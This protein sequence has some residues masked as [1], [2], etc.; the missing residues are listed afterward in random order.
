[1][2][3]GMRIGLIAAFGATL[4]SLALGAPAASAQQAVQE[5]EFTASDGVSLHATV[6][7]TAPLQPRPLV[8]EYSP[9][10]LGAGGPP[11]GPRFNYVQ[12]H[13]RGTGRSGGAWDIM[14]PREQL[15]IAESLRWLCD[16]PWSSGEIGLYGFSASAIAA[17]HAMRRTEL[18]CVRAAALLAGTS[19][20]Y[21]DLVFIGG[22]PNLVPATVVTTAI[23]GGYLANLPGRLGDEPQSVLEAS[24]GV[25]TAVN[26]FAAHPT[27]DAFWRARSFPGPSGPPEI[28]I[29]AATGFYDVE[30]RGPF[31]TFRAAR[32]SG[33][34]LL[35]I[36]AHDGAAGGSGG[37]FPAFGRW[38]EHHLLGEDNGIDAEPRV[39]LYV[40]HGGHA[41]L[42]DGAWTKVEAS[43]WPVPG[44][45]WQALHLDRRRSG[46]AL[47]LN[48]GSLALEPA[49]AATTQSAPSLP[50]NPLAT[51]P[52]T[53]A[54]V[55]EPVDTNLTEATSLTYTTPALRQP[56]MSVGPA[57][58]R[59]RLKSTSPETD[60][61]AVLSDVAPD[62]ASTPVASGRL[63][64]TFT[65]IDPSRSLT[66]PA[67][68]EIVQPYNDLS[69]KQRVPPGTAR[70]YQVELW[71]I[72]N[73]FAPGHRIRLTL[74][75]TPF[76]FLPSVPA[77]NSIVVGGPAGARLQLPVLPGS[78]LCAALG[79]PPCGP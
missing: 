73:R 15:D 76:T 13:A 69:A 68:G 27:E 49:A 63:R 52:H 65:R 34:R 79:V 14:G 36:G 48:D 17:Y 40:G 66:D 55:T 54:T 24:G 78:D 35:V 67:T 62:G 46:S 37:A 74:T 2:R 25:T 31:E 32:G 18:P 19:S 3:I 51:D 8:V 43:D 70:D 57:A 6:S 77:I 28:P 20:I 12:V 71:P 29:L 41:R 5:L 42:V 64:S 47:S 59:V 16:Q 22:M 26:A 1:M 33:S 38:F 21:R 45:A 60:I 39:Q 11:L 44:T 4:A 58:L 75:G 50:T 30:A 23:A 53:T 61:V 9:Y 7:G 10:G 72:G 56:V